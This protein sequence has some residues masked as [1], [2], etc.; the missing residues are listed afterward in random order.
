[1]S[2]NPEENHPIPVRP[3][4]A[5]SQKSG[6]EMTTARELI[7]SFDPDAG[8]LLADGF[9]EALIG[10]VEAWFAGNIHSVVALYDTARCIQILMREGMDE[11]EANEYFEFN[12]TG[13]YVG[14]GTPAFA[15]IYRQPD[16]RS[17]SDD[18]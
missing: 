6:D 7:E 11:E 15:T 3:E 18:F 12:V 9:D 8:F 2:E 1:M 13:A 14:E 16:I 4:P 17:V 5:G 10:V